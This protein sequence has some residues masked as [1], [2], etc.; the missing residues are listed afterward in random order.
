M[1]PP[2]TFL[3]ALALATLAA[4][5]SNSIAVPGD[6]GTGVP[7]VG[8]GVASGLA[9][10]LPTAT[11]TGTSTDCLSGTVVATGFT[12]APAGTMVSLF[13]VYPYGNV[14]PVQEMALA[15]DGT[16]AFSNLAAWDH[17][18]VQAET[19]FQATD[20]GTFNP[21]TA[22]VGPQAVPQTGGAIAIRVK[23]V[24]LEVLQ[25]KPA[26]GDTTVSWASA[27]VYD[28]ATGLDR[29][30]A[31]VSFS[32]GGASYPLPYTK[33]PSG[34]QSYFAY[35]PTG[36]AGATAFT[37]TTE[38]TAAA[39]PTKTWN[40]VG[41]PAAFDGAVT[42]PAAN[43]TVPHGAALPV[44][45]QAVTGASYEIVELF[46]GTGASQTATYVS[47]TADAPD[48][49]TETIPATALA[50]P[51]TYLLNV[52][53]A[54]ATCPATADGCVANDSAVPVSLTAQ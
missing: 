12:A 24:F 44:T 50:M 48:V 38:D 35:L 5:S 52:L 46:F 37:F 14:A 41:A 49:T 22:L 16:F 15:L 11:C 40:L 47:P 13:R 43:A 21:V 2:K 4:C 45:W 51:G 8:S 3:T 34:G 23:P 53:Y 39:M 32:V 18:Y 6:G 27:H 7:D 20:G 26:G 33:N 29:G 31:T 54:A 28:P 30:D 1:T 25:E 10:P 17:Y 42:T 19:V 36:V 9:P